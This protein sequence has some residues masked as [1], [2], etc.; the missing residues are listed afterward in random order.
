[1]ILVKP[2]QINPIYN[3]TWFRRIIGPCF[4]LFRIK[5]FYFYI[6]L[7]LCFFFYVYV[8]FFFKFFAALIIK[9]DEKYSKQKQSQI[10]K[11]STCFKI[12]RLN[13]LQFFGT[14]ITLFQQVLDKNRS[15][16]P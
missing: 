8:F 5:G 6:Y 2:C 15:I 12:K 13:S 14:L 16:F 10:I 11:F 9:R 7:Y 1:M 4:K 3:K